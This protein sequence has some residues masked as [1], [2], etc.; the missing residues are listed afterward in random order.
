MVKINLPTLRRR[1]RTHEGGR[2]THAPSLAAELRRAVMACLLWEDTFYESGEAIADRIKALVP[3]VPAEA[4]A[5]IAV[6]AREQ[7]KLRHVPLL[8]VREMARGPVE[9]R[10]LVAATLSRV[11]QRADELAEFLAIYWKDGRQPVSA[12]VKKGLALAFGKFDE[13]ALGKYNRDGRVKLRDALFLCHAKPPDANG[14]RFTRVE[15]KA[16]I[17]PELSDGELLFRNLVD[18][19]LEAPDTWEVQLSGGADKRE[20]FERLIAER[21]LGALALLR[22]LRNMTEAGVPR[23]LMAEALGRIDT[24]WVLPHRFIA[25]ARAVPALEDMLEAPML[26][27]AQ[28]LP[29]LAGKTVVLVDISPSM[30]DRLSA[31]SDLKRVDAA[32]GLAIIARELCSEVEVWSFSNDVK[33]VPPRRGFAL[34]DAILRSQVPNGTLLGN[35]VSAVNKRGYDRLIVVTDEQSQDPVGAPAA[36]GYMINVASY[37]NGVGYGQW[38]KIDGFSENVLRYVSE[39]E[40]SV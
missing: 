20:T 1:I 29:K 14:R 24:R 11:I 35:A 30:D 26:K 15:R 10:R 38:T 3:K 7:M 2:A 12:Q 33:M 36:R 31:K 32:C 18:G 19:R 25:A 5:A 4:V 6:E 40:K 13:Y 27:C 37:Q 21:K 8:L 34:R 23:D 22:N 16:E 39:T 9:H 17:E 28:E